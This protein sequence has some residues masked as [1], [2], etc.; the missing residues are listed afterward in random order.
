M[1]RLSHNLVNLHFQFL[2]FIESNLEILY[3]SNYFSHA[4]DSVQ[5]DSFTIGLSPTWAD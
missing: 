5:H 1:G 4:L 2:I 3:S